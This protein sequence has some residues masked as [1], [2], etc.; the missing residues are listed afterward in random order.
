MYL[1]W[2][3]SS[4]TSAYIDKNLVYNLSKHLQT[5][6]L[7]TLGL[8]TSIPP[9]KESEGKKER[10]LKYTFLPDYCIRDEARC[11]CEREL[12]VYLNICLYGIVLCIVHSLCLT[13]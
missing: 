9:H 6:V 7:I 10:T 3:T 5:R 1:Y 13:Q 2:S 4:L 8:N 11:S 12:R